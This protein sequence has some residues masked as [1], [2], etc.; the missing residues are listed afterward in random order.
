MD[1]LEDKFSSIKQLVE[2]IDIK[3]DYPDNQHLKCAFKLLNYK[4]QEGDRVA[5]YKLGWDTV[6]EYIAFEWVLVNNTRENNV[7]FNQSMLPKNSNDMFQLCYISSKNET[8]GVSEPFHFINPNMKLS[9]LDCLRSFS[10]D[11]DCLSLNYERE[12]SSLK[13]ENK[14]FRNQLQILMNMVT[15]AQTLLCQQQKEVNRLK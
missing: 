4:G 5:I 10:S 9:T 3:A 8:C 14:V 1:K 13:E 15:S 2:F 12:M 11:S 7:I 6:K